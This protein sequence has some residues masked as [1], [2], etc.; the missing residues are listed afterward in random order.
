MRGSIIIGMIS[1]SLGL[2]AQVKPIHILAS[3]V[4]EDNRPMS[5]V[6]VINKRAGAG[7]IA[8][9]NGTFKTSPLKTDTLI[10]LCAGYNELLLSFHDSSV[11]ENYPITIKMTKKIYKVKPTPVNPRIKPVDPKNND[12]KV[13]PDSTKKDTTEDDYYDK[14]S[15][16]LKQVTIYALKK[17]EEIR[18]EIESLGVKNTS[19]YGSYHS[20]SS[21]I[22]ALY[23]Q[24]SK[25]EQDKRKV[26]ELENA[27]R[28]KE[29]LRDLLALYIN[30]DIIQLT[31]DEFE[32][33]LTGI[34]MPEDFLKKATDYQIGEMIKR[35]YIEY[36]KYLKERYN[37]NSAYKKFNKAK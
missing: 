16:R 9:I 21:P 27:D 13:K 35:Q 6:M 7:F 32:E 23:E 8:E 14:D 17:P 1:L 2:S 18:K 31:D 33:F 4:S 30:Y 37:Y 20:L 28:K 5:N 3:V 10:V 26:A 12:P 24:F 29:V 25:R 15:W 19:D 11:K 34:F 36:K 22:T